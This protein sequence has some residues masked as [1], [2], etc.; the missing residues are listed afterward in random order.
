[1]QQG[2]LNPFGG[3]REL[4][5]G[6][7]EGNIAI[8]SER[9]IAEA[10]GKLVV[11]KRFPR[12]RYQ[13]MEQILDACKRKKLADG[14]IYAYSRGGE[15]VSGPSIRLAEELA[16]CWGNIEYG[17][18]ELSNQPGYSEME[19]Y[20][21]DLETNTYSAQRF[22]VRHIR[23]R[24]EG[25]KSLT[26]QRDI[27]EITANMGARRMRARIL[28]ILP[29][30][31]V[32]AAVQQCRQTIAGSSDEPLSARIE[33]MR[34]AFAKSGV[35]TQMLERRLGHVLAE[36][37]LDELPDLQGIYNAIRDGAKASEWFGAAQ[38]TGAQDEPKAGEPKDDE[39][40]APKKPAKGAPKKA[41]PKKAAPQ[42][43]DDPGED[44]PDGEAPGMAEPQGEPEEAP[45]SRPQA[46]TVDDRDL[47]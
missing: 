35:T 8:E 6:A 28:A 1:V 44:D 47:F 42:D 5:A 11:A 41:A 21:W 20:A 37:T 39:G 17:L 23:E 32:D 40:K 14:A 16:R 18:R 38:M 27:Y 29:D 33:R 19:A 30:D 45:R 10:Q 2:P 15:K 43:D 24:K 34:Q 4:S 26:G 12:D 9:A 46:S 36:T 7:A 13:S 22:T 25:D 3:R 31:V